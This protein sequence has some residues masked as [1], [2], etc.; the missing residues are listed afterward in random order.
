[1]LLVLSQL[2]FWRACIRIRESWILVTKASTPISNSFSCVS[3]LSSEVSTIIGRSFKC[4]SSLI[5]LTNSI[6]FSPGIYR[7]VIIKSGSRP[8]SDFNKFKAVQCSSVLQ[9]FVFFKKSLQNSHGIVGLS[10][11]SSALASNLTID[12]TLIAISSGL[13]MFMKWSSTCP[14]PI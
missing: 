12:F 3:G 10:S 5:N 9:N 2:I 14:S 11:T 1:M 8:F 4:A 13:R 7:S 6:P